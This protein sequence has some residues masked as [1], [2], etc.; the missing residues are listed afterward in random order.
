MECRERERDKAGADM[1][2][3]SSKPHWVLL[4]TLYFFTSS[5][6]GMQGKGERRSRHLDGCRFFETKLGVVSFTST[7]HGLQGKDER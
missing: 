4:A 5:N 7:N 1:G 6:H 2:V 3:G